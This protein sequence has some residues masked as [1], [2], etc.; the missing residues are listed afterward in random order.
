M[1]S[2][3]NQIKFICQQKIWKK[4]TDE[5]TKVN[6]NEKKQSQTTVLAGLKGRKTT[7]T[8]APKRNKIN[9]QN[10]AQQH[11]RYG[12]QS[13]TSATLSPI[14]LGLL[15]V[16][17]TFL[18]VTDSSNY[19]KWLWYRC[20]GVEKYDSS[21]GLPGLCRKSHDAIEDDLQNWLRLCAL[22]LRAAIAH[23]WL[24]ATSSA[25]RL[26][27]GRRVVPSIRYYR[28]QQLPFKRFRS[29]KY[30][31]KRTRKITN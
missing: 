18:L 13:H 22:D 14:T 19:K 29:T 8:W 11:Y 26:S 5:K 2:L 21:L 7:V 16:F 30:L 20:P 28:F 9:K 4:K 24:A 15:N 25:F 12:F 27:P 6:Q 3:S 23:R 1:V 10:N 17:Y 31:F